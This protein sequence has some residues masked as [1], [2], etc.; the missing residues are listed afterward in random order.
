MLI[1]DGDILIFIRTSAPDFSC[2]II[3]QNLTFYQKKQL[4]PISNSEQRLVFYCRVPRGLAFKQEGFVT[5]EYSFYS[6]AHFKKNL[7]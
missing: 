4:K 3:V 1:S 5:P 6:C 7:I 2:H